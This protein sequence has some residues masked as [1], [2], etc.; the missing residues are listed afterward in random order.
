M[1]L[2]QEKFWNKRREQLY[3]I[4]Q[5]NNKSL[6]SWAIITEKS[7]TDYDQWIADKQLIT[8]NASVNVK[9]KFDVVRLHE[10]TNQI[11][12]FFIDS[13][14]Y[15]SNTN[16]HAKTTARTNVNANTSTNTSSHAKIN[17]R[18]NASTAVNTNANT[19]HAD[20][21]IEV[22]F[23]EDIIGD[24]VEELEEQADGD[25]EVQ[26]EPSS[27]PHL[28]IQMNAVQKIGNVDTSVSEADA[29]IMNKMTELLVASDWKDQEV[30]DNH[31]SNRRKILAETAN[32]P[33]PKSKLFAAMYP[34]SNYILPSM[35]KLG[36][37]VNNS[38]ANNA[39]ASK[40]TTDDTS[41]DSTIED[42]TT[43]NTP[44]DIHTT[45][46][47]EL[48]PNQFN[49]V[50][51]EMKQPV[52]AVDPALKAPFIS[53]LLEISKYD[54]DELE[55][56]LFLKAKKNVTCMLPNETDINKLEPLYFK[57]ADRLLQ[58]WMDERRRK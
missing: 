52:L 11:L 57:E 18:T 5:L 12:D 42:S 35:D 45:Q 19:N 30:M 16:S 24:T 43:E 22:E 54:R 37:P 2:L 56:K 21:Q 44:A 29:D 40:S 6:Y 15:S 33:V 50:S 28:P 48:Q 47:V 9:S 3:E 4:I 41:E 27:V 51:G 38:T 26:E 34:D 14:C 17:T 31:I 32:K 39:D 53:P 13:D 46:H 8:G 58:C 23:T 20:S 49:A 10:L 1:S 25:V 7:I 36:D 55:Q